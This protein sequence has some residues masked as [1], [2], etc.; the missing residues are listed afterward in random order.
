MQTCFSTSEKRG[1]GQS[2]NGGLCRFVVLRYTQQ[3]IK[4]KKKH[5]ACMVICIG[6]SL[7]QGLRGEAES[8]PTALVDMTV[9]IRAGG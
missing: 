6:M 9:R 4:Q 7:A 8:L 2:A 3:A 1:P 5:H